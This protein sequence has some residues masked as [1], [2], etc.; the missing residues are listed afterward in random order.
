MLT[1][2]YDTFEDSHTLSPLH[3]TFERIL[4]LHHMI[5]VQ[6]AGSAVTHYYDTRLGWTFDKIERSI[7]KFKGYEIIEPVNL[8]EP[9]RGNSKLDRVINLHIKR[10]ETLVVRDNFENSFSWFSFE[11]AV[12]YFWST[13][14]IKGFIEAIG[15]YD[16]ETL[17]SG[18]TI[19]E[20][21]SRMPPRFPKNHR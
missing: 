3:T 19:S 11:P 1:I 6:E 10:N 17:R 21:M 16:L 7:N 2:H 14:D 8:C 4:Q 12:G 9:L 13:K 15:W 5:A 18:E 20:C